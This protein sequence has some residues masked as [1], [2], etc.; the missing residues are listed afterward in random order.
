MKRILF[1]RPDGGLSVVI[2]V[3][4]TLGEA[5][6][7]TEADALERA[8]AKLPADAL[9][10]RVVDETDIPTDRTYRNAWMDAGSGSV[11]HD[12]T[13]ARE[14]HKNKLRELRAPKLAALD[15]D[16]IR[17]DEAGN[18]ALKTQIAQQKQALRDVTA[19]PAIAAAQTVDEL[20][21]VIP[22]IF[23]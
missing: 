10:V 16:Y 13:K 4:N 15:V 14:I 1:T 18:A 11:T 3:I 21:L 7:F 6:G 12:M 19:D 23:I 17:A 9:N 22:E 5:E 2:P 20:K 8:L